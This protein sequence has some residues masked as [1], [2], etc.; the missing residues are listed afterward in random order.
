METKW[1]IIDQIIVI[2]LN[3]FLAV[4]ASN[5]KENPCQEDPKTFKIMRWMSHSVLSQNTLESYLHDL[6][7]ATD[8]ERNLMTEKYALMENMIPHPEHLNGIIDK[9]ATQEVAWMKE[10][11]KMYPEI[12]QDNMNQFATYMICEYET[13]SQETLLLLAEDIKSA[14]DSKR[15]LVEMRYNN[16]FKR[17]G[18]S[19]ISQG[20]EKFINA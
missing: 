14:Q 19:S 13:Y 7:N 16:L 15:N 18:Y 1:D 12:I 9:I 20:C 3:M 5:A 2:E 6:M 11:K 10:L 8:D 17:M 4:R